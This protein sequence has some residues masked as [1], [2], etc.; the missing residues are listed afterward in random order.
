[1]I[2]DTFNILSAED[3]IA[4][5]GL[6][7][8]PDEGGYYKET[9]RD[10]G[11]IPDSVL[12][13]HGGPRQYS[14]SIYYLV[15][16]DEFSALHAVRST[17]V[18]HFY[19]GD[20]VR[21]M[22]INQDGDLKEIILGSDFT[23]RQSPQTV[24]EPDVWQGTKLIQGGQWALLGCTVAPGFDFADFTLGHREKLIEAFPQ[25]EALIVEFTR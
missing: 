1:M 2:E 6:I 20:P 15:T 8:L 21:M 7:P 17:E 14:T 18:F 25:H 24:V 3:V 22:Q 23:N 9:F 12:P 4:K 11:I 10:N 16:P 13:D 5:L 19:A